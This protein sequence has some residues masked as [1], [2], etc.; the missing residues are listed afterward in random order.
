MREVRKQ[1]PR[2]DG[3][4]RSQSADDDVDPAPWSN[5]EAV[6]KERVHDSAERSCDAG[7]GELGGLEDG[8]PLAALGRSVPAAGEDKAHRIEGALDRPEREAAEDQLMIC[9]FS[10][11]KD[12]GRTGLRQSHREGDAAPCENGDGHEASRPGE[13]SAVEEEADGH[14]PEHVRRGEGGHAGRVLVT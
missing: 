1:K 10:D 14:L 7:R 11:E 4:H 12:G 6:V 5:A 13:P 8:D 3:E 2:R 9:S